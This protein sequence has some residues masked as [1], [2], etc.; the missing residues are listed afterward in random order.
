MAKRGTNGKGLALRLQRGLLANG[1]A[2][3][4]NVDA[5]AARINAQYK[6]GR[7]WDLLAEMADLFCSARDRYTGQSTAQPWRQFL[8]ESESLATD[9]QKRMDGRKGQKTD[10]EMNDLMSRVAARDAASAARRA[11]RQGARV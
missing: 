8:N 5:L 2:G 3:E 1:V 11:A 10:T 7:S 6:T 4:T 9:A